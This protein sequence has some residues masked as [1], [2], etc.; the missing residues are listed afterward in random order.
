VKSANT[1][2]SH[3]ETQTLDTVSRFLQGKSRSTSDNFETSG[4]LPTNPPTRKYLEV[5][6]VADKKQYNLRGSSLTQTRT[7]VEASFNQITL[8]YQRNKLNPAMQIVM[9]GL[10]IFTNDPYTPTMSGTEAN[11]GS[12]LDLFT[13]WH[14]N[15]TPAHDNA[16][17]WS[18]FNFDG[19]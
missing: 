17:L 19:D 9:V 6:A 2:A 1:G 18:G 4:T 7:Y 14:P 12:L 16:H 8:A 10:T 13:A 11:S 5:L 3:H 15:Q